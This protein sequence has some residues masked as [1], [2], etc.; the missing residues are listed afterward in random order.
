MRLDEMLERLRSV[1][2]GVLVGKPA[3]ITHAYLLQTLSDAVA[4]RVCRSDLWTVSQMGG[5]QLG[6]TQIAQLQPVG[7]PELRQQSLTRW[8]SLVDYVDQEIQNLESGLDAGYS[9]PKSVVRRVIDQVDGLLALDIEQSPFYSPA[10][11]DSDE[12]FAISWS[13]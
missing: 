12:S 10:T 4:Q 2:A 6:M 8:A 13:T 9:A 11:R 3:W 7:S 5:W 1:D